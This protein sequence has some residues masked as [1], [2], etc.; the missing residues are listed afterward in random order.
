MTSPANGGTIH[1]M[2][3]IGTGFLSGYDYDSL[4]EPSWG[5]P[6]YTWIIDYDGDGDKDIVSGNGTRIEV[7]LNTG[8]GFFNST[9]FYYYNGWG[10]AQ[11]TF[12]LDR[13]RY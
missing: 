2:L 11:Q 3:S 13:S 6:A 1:M 9:F 8:G 12:A 7:K 10:L 5:A 4:V